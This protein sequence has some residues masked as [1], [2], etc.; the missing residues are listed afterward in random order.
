MTRA[1]SG[2]AKGAHKL[3]DNVTICAAFWLI[4]RCQIVVQN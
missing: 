4:E 2:I 1:N 3:V